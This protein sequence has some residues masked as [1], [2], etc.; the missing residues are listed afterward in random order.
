LLFVIKFL[1]DGLKAL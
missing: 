1:A